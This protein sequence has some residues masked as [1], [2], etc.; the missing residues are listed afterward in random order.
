ML[1]AFT[2]HGLDNA[3]VAAEILVS[4]SKA[5]SFETTMMF[6]EDADKK[7]ID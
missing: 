2:E 7:M 5:V 1:K 3:E 4:L 6:A